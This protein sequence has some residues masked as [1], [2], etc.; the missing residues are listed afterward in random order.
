MATTAVVLPKPLG[1]PEE[2]S[3]KTLSTRLMTVGLYLLG[4][5]AAAATVW[6]VDNEESALEV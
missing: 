4:G 3:N 5:L 1:L 2:A 6:M